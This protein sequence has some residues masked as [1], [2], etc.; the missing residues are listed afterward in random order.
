METLHRIAT[1]IMVGSIECGI[2][3]GIE[4]MG[5]TLGLDGGGRQTRVNSFNPRLQQLTASQKRM[6]PDHDRYF[7]VPFPDYVLASPPIQSMPQTAQ[8]VAETWSL[9]RRELDEFSA[10]S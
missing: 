5:R 8:N 10:E 3:L 1:A 4:R 7:S 9:A 6:A 2:A